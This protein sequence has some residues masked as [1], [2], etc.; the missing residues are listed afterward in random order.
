MVAEALQDGG[1]L[2]VDLA[3]ASSSSDRASSAVRYDA[4]ASC[5]RPACHS[6]KAALVVTTSPVYAR[7]VSLTRP[8]PAAYCTGAA[9]RR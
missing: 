7:R 4:A 9:R 2:A 8:A 6:A 3:S 1:E 5:R